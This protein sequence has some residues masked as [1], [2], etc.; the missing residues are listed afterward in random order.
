MRTERTQIQA[1]ADPNQTNLLFIWYVHL[2]CSYLKVLQH[3]F[4]LTCMPPDSQ[5]TWATHNK[6]IIIKQLLTIIKFKD[7]RWQVEKPDGMTWGVSFSLCKGLS[8]L[9]PEVTRSGQGHK[10]PYSALRKWTGCNHTRSKAAL[11][12]SSHNTAALY[13]YNWF[14]K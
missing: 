3:L 8:E 12:S 5:R 9:F 4:I 14:G 6:E 2:W 13:M 11:P 7:K 1:S 10:A